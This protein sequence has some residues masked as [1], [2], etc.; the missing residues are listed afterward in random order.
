MM[1]SSGADQ[2]TSSSWVEWSQSGL[3]VAYLFDARY[4][5]AK[6]IVSTITGKMISSIHTV[7]RTLN[8]PCWR[9]TSPALSSTNSTEE[10]LGG[11]ECCIPFRYG[12]SSS[13]LTKKYII[14][15]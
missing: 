12:C 9:E 14:I 4:F 2:M 13:V 1:I 11:K 6:K 7:H 15:K 8:S 5:H 3:Y 10:W